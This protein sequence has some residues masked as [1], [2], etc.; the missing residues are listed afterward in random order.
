MPLLW[1]FLGCFVLT[2]TLEIRLLA[3]DTPNTDHMLRELKTGINEQSLHAQ[4]L[5][6]LS[7]L[8]GKLIILSI[9]EGKSYQKSYKKHQKQPIFPIIIIFFI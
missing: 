2:S 5:S 8:V 9:P 6:E 3:V 1:A 7:S 4:S